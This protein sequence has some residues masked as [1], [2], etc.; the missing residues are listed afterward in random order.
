MREIGIEK[1]MRMVDERKYKER[2]KDLKL[3]MVGV[4]MKF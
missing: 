3:E 1:R 2:I 4:E